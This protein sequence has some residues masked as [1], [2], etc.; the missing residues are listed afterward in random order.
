MIWRDDEGWGRLR[1]RLPNNNL[2]LSKF[3]AIKESDLEDP[4]HAYPTIGGETLAQKR[5]VVG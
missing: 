5:W 3:K 2:Q 1:P 4:L